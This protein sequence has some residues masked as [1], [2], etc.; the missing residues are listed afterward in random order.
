MENDSKRNPSDSDSSQSLNQP[1]NAVIKSL[2]GQPLFL[3]LLGMGILFIMMAQVVPNLSEVL[4]PLS[5][6]IILAVIIWGFLETKK[7]QGGLKTGGVHVARNVKAKDSTLESG[8]V[9]SG[10]AQ[11]GGAT[12]NIKI[13]SK[14]DL[15]GVKIKTGDIKINTA[16]EKKS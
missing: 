12:G 8:S 3:L 6:I 13:D 10:K 5:G 7:I 15:S 1:L 2:K 4:M 11:Q 14:A 9:S 16:K